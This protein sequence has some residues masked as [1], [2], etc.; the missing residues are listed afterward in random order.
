M[1]PFRQPSAR[2][3]FLWGPWPGS[4]PPWQAPKVEPTTESSANFQGK[5]ELGALSS[6]D[7]I[8]EES[9]LLVVTQLTLCNP[10]GYQRP[11]SLE[12]L[13]RTLA[14]SPLLSGPALL[15]LQAPSPHTLQASAAQLRACQVVLTSSECL[16][17]LFSV[18]PE[19]ASAHP[20]SKR[21]SGVWVCGR[22]PPTP[23]VS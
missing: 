4:E 15:H 22:V 2:H 19:N 7:K 5:S 3:S 6:G 16:F 1:G 20:D 17:T 8:R 9:R 23:C 18:C 21:L 13:S 14:S 12:L 11:D 10:P